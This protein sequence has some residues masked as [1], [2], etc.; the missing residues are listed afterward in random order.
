MESTGFKTSREMRAAENGTLLS[1][2]TIGGAASAAA[3]GDTILQI[4]GD[5][6]ALYVVAP[7]AQ[8]VTVSAFTIDDGATWRTIPAAV[9]VYA[10]AARLVEKTRKAK[11]HHDIL[12]PFCS[13]HHADNK[14]E[15][16]TPRGAE[17][18]AFYKMRDFI[19]F[20]NLLCGFKE[21][22]LVVY[23]DKPR[24]V[25]A[26]ALLEAI[27]ACLD[28]LKHYASTHGPGPD[29]RLVSLLA[30]LQGVENV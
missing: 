11:A 2:K 20:D 21:G 29:G 9:P 4:M 30:A 5:T 15:W 13:L 1:Y 25:V 23:L 27:T 28:D 24:A 3:A 17:S 10:P 12:R 8:R 14:T 16:W 18:E 26:P 6:R 7:A 19:P 22:G